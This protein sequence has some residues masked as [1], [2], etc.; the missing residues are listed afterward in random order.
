MGEAQ[1]YIWL[2]GF[3]Y[4][5]EGKVLWEKI[6]PF[7]Q[8][9]MTSAPGVTDYTPTSKQAWAKL[10]SGMGIE[11]WTPEDNDRYWQAEGVDASINMQS[12]GP[13]VTTL[14]SFGA[15]PVRIIKYADKIWA[16]GPSKVAYWDGAA[17][18]TANP[19]TPLATPTDAIIFYGDI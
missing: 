16:I 4:P 9:L 11:K 10:K 2:G 3:H 15:E 19:T 5:I 7:P 8:Q 17:W 13:L 18:Q 12:L 14:G 6:T 1:R